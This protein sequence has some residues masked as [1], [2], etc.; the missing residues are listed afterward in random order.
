MLDNIL[1][2]LNQIIPS[3]GK[4]KTL[5]LEFEHVPFCI[6]YTFV[7]ISQLEQCEL[8]QLSWQEHEIIRITVSRAEVL[9]F[10]SY[11]CGSSYSRY[12][13]NQPQSSEYS[14]LLSHIAVPDNS[15]TT[16]VMQW[17]KLVRATL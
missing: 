5:F 2:K 1:H 14:L 15:K 13:R 8:G 16:I 12:S 10:S 6:F 4:A 17:E 9:I 3:D 11:C 7:A